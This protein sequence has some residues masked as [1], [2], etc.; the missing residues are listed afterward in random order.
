VD[1]ASSTST[2]SSDSTDSTDHPALPP[3]LAEIVAEFAEVTEPQRL[4]LLLEFSRDLP[5]LPAHLLARHAAM[6][7]VPE[8]QAALFLLVEVDAPGD[9]G[10]AVHLFFDAP[11]QAPTTRGFAAVLHA[12]LD[13]IAVRD[14]LAVPDNVPHFLGISTAVSPRRLNGMAAMVYRIKRQVREKSKPAAAG[15]GSGPG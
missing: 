12:G 13:G 4:E 5:A 15:T 1:R 14:L 11:A 6:E 8:C 9:A 10:S 7:P 2:A 3:G